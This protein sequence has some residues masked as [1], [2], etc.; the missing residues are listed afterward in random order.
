MR[1][2]NALRGVACPKC[3][4][5]DQ[6][7]ID[8][9]A[10]ATVI[11]NGADQIVD[12][13]W[14]DTSRT[15]CTSCDHVGP[16]SEFQLQHVTTDCLKCHESIR[17][18]GTGWVRVDGSRGCE[19]KPAELTLGEFRDR[20][21]HLP[22]TMTMVAAVEDIVSDLGLGVVPKADELAAWPKLVLHQTEETEVD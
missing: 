15:R 9:R 4:S 21:A 10:T 3:G 22:D 20:T 17:W 18:T 1:N 19:H 5:D 14:D 11:D 7:E 12:P 8:V 13:T 6:F 16:F 2:T